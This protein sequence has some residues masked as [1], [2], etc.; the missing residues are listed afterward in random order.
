MSTSRLADRQ[1]RQRAAQ[2]ALRLDVRGPVSQ[3]LGAAGIVVEADAPL[4]AP[5]VE[6]A[7]PTRTRRGAPPARR[8]V[9]PFEPEAWPTRTTAEPRPLSGL[10][11]D[12]RRVHRILLDTLEIRSQASGG[13][14][15]TYADR[16]K[17]E[18]LDLS[19]ID[20]KLGKMEK[21]RERFGR[22]GLFAGVGML[23]S[24]VAVVISAVSRGDA[25]AALAFGL[26][27][28]LL[29]LVGGAIAAGGAPAAWG[30]SRLDRSERRIYLALREL[31]VLADDGATSDALSQADA[32]IDRLA[33]ADE[34]PRLHLDDAPAPSASAPSPRRARTR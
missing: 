13:F 16:K 24:T 18:A 10:T 27:F 12:E 22:V 32:L 9:K 5:A 2:A 4:A 29:V 26:A 33:D 1:I 7:A 17:L 15:P 31:A 3:A 11:A 34:G 8:V 14:G 19:F 20:A 28:G 30:T 25:G 21:N 6:P 23:L